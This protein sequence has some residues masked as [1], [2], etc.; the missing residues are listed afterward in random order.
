[1]F[2]PC[3]TKISK[4]ET[5]T[6]ALEFCF[7]RFGNSVAIDTPGF[8]MTYAEL[9]GMTR[10]VASE[11]RSR[12]S[13]QQLKS[14]PIAILMSRS[15]EFYVAQV[16]ILRAGGFFLPIDP[17]QPSERIT[18]LLSDSSSSLLLVREGD[19]FAVEESPIVS[20]SIDVERWVNESRGHVGQSS[21]TAAIATEDC[22]KVDG[23]D[24]AYMIY[25][26]GS[27][28]RPKGVPIYHRS[29]CNLCHW[30]ADEFDLK[31]GD[32]TLQMISVGFDASLEEIFPTLVTG[33]TLVPI[34][35]EAL[36]SMEKFLDFI[37]QQK[38]QNLHLPAAFWHALAASFE[39][40]ESLELPASVQTVVLGGEKADPT[41]VE[42]WFSQIGTE[43]R[44]INAYGP[45]ETT[46]AASCADLRPGVEPTIG[47][48][49]GNVS[50]CVCDTDGRPVETGQPGELF[51]GGIGVAIGYWNRREL[52]AEKFVHSPLKDGQR[53]YRTG[54][55][56]KLNEDGNYEFV[57]R[58]DDQIKLRGYRIE[59]GEI[60][61]CLRNHP[62]ISQ[63]HVAV[64][65]LSNGKITQRLLIG[66]VVTK[67]DDDPS[68]SELQEFLGLQLPAYMI[69]T[70]IVAMESFPVTT[71]GKLDIDQFPCPTIEP[72]TDSNSDG[73]SE[74]IRPTEQKI[75]KIWEQV[76][77]TGGLTR[78]ANFFQIGG[79]SLLAMRLV[80]LLES[81]FPGPVIPVAALIPNPTI[82]AM[83]DYIDR[84][85][86][87]L[88][89]ATAAQNWPLLTRMGSSQHPIS[90][91]CLHAAGGG[92]MFYRQLFEGFERATSEKETSVAIL[93]SASLYQEKS[94]TCGH[95]SIAGMARNY[96][97]CLVDA[98]CDQKLTLVGYSFGSLLAYEM[99][100]LLRAQGYV[101][102]KIV[103]IDCPNP[104]IMRP[105]NLLS[106]IWCRIRTFRDRIAEY[107]L[108]INRK[109]NL[110]RLKD[111]TKVN[112]PPTVELRPLALELVFNALAESYPTKPL[113]IEMRL[114]KCQYPH[115]AYHIPDDYGWTAMVS[116]LTAVE[117]PGGHN[118]IFSD[119]HLQSLI[120]AF[121]EALAD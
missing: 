119:P 76:L 47:K 67:S 71:G 115:A 80:L 75:A 82:A 2:S 5:L 37:G 100:G 111:L 78:E 110:R 62:Q 54:D 102:E 106:K 56:V 11:L 90:V 68:E 118:T 14:E 94:M 60:S 26:S 4:P 116:A 88:V 101:V 112:L 52:S 9:D 105:R 57:G 18:F 72:T 31:Q 22:G 50:F 34:Q 77:G 27:T 41:L 19:S 46:V 33:G 45:T 93:E 20:V 55:L 69:P 42:S 24:F 87:R 66:Y 108:I 36:N 35:P 92:G 103:N 28:G 15:V 13:S 85:Q 73:E 89:V 91:A 10:H 120:Q 109:R 23:S 97:D 59:P 29:I 3:E 99:A 32:R 53:Y 38:V 48:P 21:A 25:T 39:T 8:K 17:S 43:V 104:I 79:D 84:R 83:A 61:A 114:I 113:D 44:L 49:I 58:I 70:K 95:E 1:M 65:L 98:G 16:A 86:R 40:H 117:I 121:H 7:V 63:A 81:E 6:D 51:I 107:K 12:C 64:R 96:V 74:L 30:W